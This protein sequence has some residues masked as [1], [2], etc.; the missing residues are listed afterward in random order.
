[1]MREAPT[2][3]AARTAEEAMDSSLDSSGAPVCW[4]DSDTELS[5]RRP[6]LSTPSRSPLPR[7][8]ALMLRA[9]AS[10]P[11]SVSASRASCDRPQS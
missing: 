9:S 6:R 5:S 11:P 10:R 8:V 4:R 7:D 2:L 3:S 1:M